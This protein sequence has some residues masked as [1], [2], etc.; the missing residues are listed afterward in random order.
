MEKWKRRKKLRAAEYHLRRMSEEYERSTEI[1]NYELECF[2]VTIRS[3]L[4]V[5]LYDFAKKFQ[6][7]IDVNERLDYN[8]FRNRATK[9]NNIR[10]SEFIEWWQKTKKELENSKVGFLLKK[11]D[12]AVHRGSVEP[13]I[14]KVKKSE[15]IVLPE[16]IIYIRKDEKGNVIEKYRSPP[17]SP[18]TIEPTPPVKINMYF[19]D[20]REKNVIDVC[21]ELYEMV[22]GK[23]AEAKVKFNDC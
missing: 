3:V 6:L 8:T 1:F 21:K 11:R 4:D 18:K 12:I 9:K 19:S 20:N 10:A 2:L 13:D 16:S 17:E 23:V 14:K 22:A 7:G 5:L 15:K